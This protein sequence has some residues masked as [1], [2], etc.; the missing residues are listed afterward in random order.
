MAKAFFRD[1]VHTNPGPK[2][3]SFFGLISLMFFDY[4]VF[5]EWASHTCRSSLYFVMSFLSHMLHVKSVFPSFSGF[6]L[7]L[8]SSAV[9]LLPS[10]HFSVSALRRDL[11]DEPFIIICLPFWRCL[12]K[13]SFR[14]YLE[15]HSPSHLHISFLLHG[16][17]IRVYLGNL[18]ERRPCNKFYIYGICSLY[19]HGEHPFYD[20]PLYAILRMSCHTQ[21]TWFCSV[22]M[23][24]PHTY[25]GQVHMFCNECFV[26]HFLYGITFPFLESYASCGIHLSFVISVQFSLY[27][28]I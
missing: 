2:F 4:S 26:T 20:Q 3:S 27:E 11:E 23:N 21:C 7:C 14:A 22:L 6:L 15:G 28:L 18:I 17:L 9:S 1:Y 12:S 16:Y 5:C 24:E 8:L 25:N 19:S 10:S 13:S